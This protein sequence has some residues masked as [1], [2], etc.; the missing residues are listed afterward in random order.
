V[1]TVDQEAFDRG[2][3]A[4]T[5]SREAKSFTLGVNWYP[6]AFIKYYATFE[7]TAFDGGN[8]SRPTENVI[9]FRAQVAF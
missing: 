4:A 7:R 5:A 1:L 3:A 9:L 6:V 2:F 8:G